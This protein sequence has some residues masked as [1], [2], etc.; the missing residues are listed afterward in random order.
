[1]LS[2]K[3]RRGSDGTF[4]GVLA[5]LVIPRFQPKAKQNRR[6]ARFCS[7]VEFIFTCPDYT[8]D[9]GPKSLLNNSILLLLSGGA[10]VHRCD[11]RPIFRAG[12]SRWRATA[13]RAQ[14]VFQQTAWPRFSSPATLD[15]DVRLRSST[16]K[17]PRISA[18]LVITT[19][20]PICRY[21]SD[22]KTAGYCWR[23]R[24]RSAFPSSCPSR[25]A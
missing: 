11:E 24:R 15:R 2:V 25:L 9:V 3:T 4:G 7:N 13:R 8:R 10:A 16:Q 20:V 12:F 5:R 18:G 14:G 21:P 1:M 6:A 17:K 23:Y 22:S 19:D